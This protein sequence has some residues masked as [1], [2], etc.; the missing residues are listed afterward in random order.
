MRHVQGGT[1]ASLKKQGILSGFSAVFPQAVENLYGKCEQFGS[2]LGSISAVK[3]MEVVNMA[4]AHHHVLQDPRARYPRPEYDS[5]SQDLPG[6]VEPMSPTPDHGEKTYQGS[7]KLDGLV[8]LITGGDSGIGRAVAIAY[9]REGADIVFTYLSEDDDAKETERLVRGAGRTVISIRMDQA[10]NRE[11]CE[12]AV[13]RCIDEFGHLDILVNNAAFQKTYQSLEDIPD[14]EISYAFETN[15]EAFFHF[16]RAALRHLPP[17]GSII[18]AT[19]IQAFD[20][21]PHL[22]PYASTKAAI[23]NFTLSLAGEAIEKGVR[24]NAVAPGPVWTPLIPATMPQEKVQQFGGN[25]LLKRPAQ[26][27]EL[28]PLFVFLASSDASYIT[29]EI[30]GVTGGRLQV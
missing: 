26:P 10:N 19:S 6:H 30:Y 4:H 28:A 18:N 23:A 8:A 27:A 16:S 7:S 1:T 25:T 2:A 24:V 13:Q 22:S 17:G 3:K 20:P 12:Q 5:Q 14:E 11:G 15:I 9:A 21:T 29:G